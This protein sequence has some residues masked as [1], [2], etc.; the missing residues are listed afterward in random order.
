MDRNPPWGETCV[1]TLFSRLVEEDL[2][3]TEMWNQTRSEYPVS[4]GDY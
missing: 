1:L 4:H 3:D 2:Y